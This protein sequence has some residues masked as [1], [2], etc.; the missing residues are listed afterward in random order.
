MTRQDDKNL[1]Q[2]AIDWINTQPLTPDSNRDATHLYYWI[3]QGQ[4]VSG[5][6]TAIAI[7]KRVLHDAGVLA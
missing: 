6:E 4:P 3:L 1:C 2:Q 7:A 5:E